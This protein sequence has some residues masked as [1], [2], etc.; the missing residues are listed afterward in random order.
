MIE[1]ILI[2]RDHALICV[3]IFFSRNTTEKRAIINSHGFTVA[4]YCLAFTVLS[5][6]AHFIQLKQLPYSLLLK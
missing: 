5:I 1:K 6:T 4:L 2:I 3:I